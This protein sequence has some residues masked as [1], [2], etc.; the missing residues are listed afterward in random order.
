M[1]L[2]V[3]AMDLFS[4]GEDLRLE[5]LDGERRTAQGWDHWSFCRSPAFWCGQVIDMVGTNVEA[6][7]QK[8]V[9]AV[10]GDLDLGLLG[11]GFEVAEIPPLLS[12]EPQI[13]SGSRPIP[14][15]IRV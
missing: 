6:K 10:G 4:V 9:A 7:G 13:G 3:Q 1:G 8:N 11:T 2:G 15:T 14:W 12:K 5:C